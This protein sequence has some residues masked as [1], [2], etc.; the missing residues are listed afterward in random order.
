MRTFLW[1]GTVASL[2]AC[3]G[4]DGE[5]LPTRPS[6]PSGAI[7]IGQIVEAQFEAY[8]AGCEFGDDPYP[9]VSYALD[10][11]RAG[12]LVIRA[13]SEGGV[14]PMFITFAAPG[15]GRQDLIIGQSPLSV[16][17]LARAGQ[18]S[19]TVGVDAPY[20]LRSALRYRLVATLEASSN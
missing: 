8:S 1:A 20:G 18:L 5:R 14:F 2:L 16:S 10:V 11:P 7:A 9:C 19:F 13:E 17:V 15:A 3:S 4:C 12:R 6:A